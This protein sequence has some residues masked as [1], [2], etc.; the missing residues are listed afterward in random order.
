MRLET[1]LIA[2]P[3]IAHDQYSWATSPLTIRGWQI[4]PLST[5]DAGCSG[6][7]PSPSAGWYN[8]DIQWLFYDF[9]VHTDTQ[10]SCLFLIFR[11]VHPSLYEWV[12]VRPS[13]GWMDGWSVR[14]LFFP[15]LEMEKCL[16]ENHWGRPTLTLLKVLNVLNVLKVLNVLN[17]LNMPIGS[18]AQGPLG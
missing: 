18:I 16:N 2:H 14:N 8:P 7:Q 13:D 17:V 6:L 4:Y 3:P 9:T 11:W 5:C 15:M 10:V 12:S 1:L